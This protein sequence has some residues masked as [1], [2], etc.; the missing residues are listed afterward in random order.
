[1]IRHLDKS[2]N[3]KRL[4]ADVVIVGTGPAGMS[5]ALEFLNTKHSVILVESGNFGAQKAIN[6]LNKGERTGQ[7]YFD[8]S[9]CR[10]R[11][12]GGS[13]NCWSGWCAPF[14]PSDFEAHEW[15][16]HSGWPVSFKDI[17][18]FYGKASQRLQ[19]NKRGFSGSA[20]R[21][22]DTP[23][24][25]MAPLLETNVF[26]FSRPTRFGKRYRKQ[27]QKAKNINCLLNATV[28][29]I[30]ME[31]NQKAVRDLT[32]S[33]S[34][35]KKT[36]LLKGKQYVLATGG[37][38]NARLLLTSNHQQP[39]GIGNEHDNVG[40]YFMEH[41][42]LYAEGRFLNST[43]FDSM[44]LYTRHKNRRQWIRGYLS[45]PS[46]IRQKEQILSMSMCL[47]ALKKGELNDDDRD[48]AQSATSFDGTQLIETKDKT[49]FYTDV[50]VEQAPNP[51]SRV[52]LSDKK[53]RLG[54]PKASLNW[55]LTDL[56]HQSV[57][58]TQTIL[59]R[60]LGAQGLSRL[61]LM[62]DDKTRYTKRVQG[63]CHHMG[64]TRMHEDPRFG[65]VDK[66]C[67]VFN[68]DNLYVAGSSIFTTSSAANPTL[69]LVAF[70]LRLAKWLKGE[71]K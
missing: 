35:S 49:L 55:Q 10:S 2:S 52:T 21:G 70:A 46:E 25:K 56:D 15:L 20:W 18:P 51:A 8:L 13:S 39:K 27:I 58:K 63:G 41:P 5:L 37:I 71:L 47:G 68:V 22:K 11:Y 33:H 69:T 9:K 29:Q 36:V 19:L 42:H 34:L 45:V 48:I 3:S 61:K 64:T 7:K 31:A 62:I 43:A 38:E 28:T 4:E 26:K 66:N 14:T 60:A 24:W 59:G 12:F 32:V 17:E 40:R 65:V 53:D 30:N 57:L 50:R 44:K 6:D 54:V 23:L 67:K 16:P 1:V